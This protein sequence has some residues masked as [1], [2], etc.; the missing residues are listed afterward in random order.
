MDITP[1]R[2]PQKPRKIQLFSKADWEGLKSHMSSFANS[3]CN[4]YN[5]SSPVNTMWSAFRGAC[6]VHQAMDKYIPTKMARCKDRVPWITPELRKLLRKQTKLFYKQRGSAKASRASQHYRSLKSLVQRT[7]RQAYWKYVNNIISDNGNSDDAADKPKGNK[8]FWTFIKHKKQ[9]A[10]GVAPLRHNGKLVH[11]TVHKATILNAQ[12]QSVFNKNTPLGLNHLCH[13][14]LDFCTT[15][16]DSKPQEKMAPFTI[17]EE[18]V[19]KL[20]NKLKPFKAAGPDML[21]PL[22]LKELAAEIAPI[23]TIIF[24]ASL[25][26]QSVP[27]DWKTANITPIFKKGEK[28]RAENYRPVSLTCICSKLMEHVMASQLMSHLDKH[29]ILHSL[30]HGFRAKLSCETQLLEFADDIFKSLRDNSQSDV[31]IMDF[32]KAFDKVSHS[33]LLHKLQRYGAT[34]TFCGWTRSF[35]SGRTQQVVI[36][37]EASDPIPITSGVPQGSVLGPILFLVYINDMPTYTKHATVRLFA[38]DT[39]VYMAIHNRDECAK[40]QEDIAA[41]GDWEKEWL[42][43]FHPD[44]CNV[45]RISKKRSIIKFPYALHNQVLAEADNAKYLG[46]NINNK[47]SW[48]THIDQMTAKSNKR[49]GFIKRNLKIPD[50][51]LKSMAYKS[52]V[53]PTLEYAS[54]VW[55]PH[56]LTA[57]AQLEKVQRRAARWAMGDYRRES[58]VTIMLRTLNWRLLALRRVDA[59]LCLMFKIVHGLVGIDSSARI[60]MQRDRVHLQPMYTK[61]AYYAFSFFPRTITDW[62][63]LEPNILTAPSL[64]AFRS[65]LGS[66]DHNLPYAF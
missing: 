29:N 46:V 21:R 49:L 47:M 18:G 42:M 55:D 23:L 35:L 11:D 39:L 9:E 56:T 3:F 12:F 37:G 25:K 4:Q 16:E 10:R 17:T 34:D 30:Q 48:N 65:R 43:E 28:Y 33:H 27:D 22:I 62:N 63:Y 64:Q 36:D 45:L 53:R 51:D 2:H 40:L 44:K 52:L 13:K 8:R 58:S 24:N 5:E 41:L 6:A 66:V 1:I 59:R 32:S 20:L 19:V 26:Q 38:D 54:A 57:A 7:T 31:V 14:A 61:P 50:Q 15:S 60:R